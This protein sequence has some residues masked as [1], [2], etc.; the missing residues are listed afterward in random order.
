VDGCLNRL[1]EIGLVVAFITY[2]VAYL[3]LLG[4]YYP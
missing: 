4:E 2:Q 3:I 1:E